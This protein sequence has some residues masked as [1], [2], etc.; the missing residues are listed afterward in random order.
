MKN[1]PSNYLYYHNRGWVR[2]AKVIPSPN[3]D[4]RPASTEIDVLVIHA[5]SL[6]PR[7][8]GTQYVEDLFT[9]RL[10]TDIH[11]AFMDIADRAVSSHFYIKRDGE[12]IQFV[13][14]H[15]RAWHAGKS[16]FNG[17]QR[18][19]DFSIGIELEGCDEDEFEPP[20]YEVLAK[21]TKCLQST[22]PLITSANIVGHSD[23]APNRKTDPG[24]FFDWIRY[25]Q[26]I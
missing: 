11:P 5:I 8:Y 16:I 20:Q 4:H 13:A 2:G 24:P 6:P 21:L 23:I 17:R 12:V 7:C 18:V 10:D 1:A 25:F 14:T 3:H 9:N 26:S 15:R 22:Y 19:N